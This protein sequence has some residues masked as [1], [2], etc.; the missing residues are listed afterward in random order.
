M[1]RAIKPRPISAYLSELARMIRQIE[2]DDSLSNESKESIRKQLSALMSEM[3][4]AL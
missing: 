4:K 2:V 1:P 3:Q